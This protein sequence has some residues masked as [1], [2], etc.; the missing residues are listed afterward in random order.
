M[1]EAGSKGFSRQLCA[2]RAPFVTGVGPEQLNSRPSLLLTPLP[3]GG[4]AGGGR[5]GEVKKKRRKWL[6]R[7]RE[8][9]G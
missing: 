9:G 1:M 3:V 4:V 2:S 7:K 8:T 6:S 5:S